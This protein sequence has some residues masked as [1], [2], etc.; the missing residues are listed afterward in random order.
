[1]DRWFGKV[2]IVTGA[3]SGIGETIVEALVKHGIK[4]VGIARSMNRLREL[5]AKFG[6][7]KFYPMECDL[8]KEEDILKAF[9]W[10]EKEL[11]G[12]DI[13]V[14]SAGALIKTPIIDSPTENFHKVID[15]NLIAPAICARETIQSLKKR[16]AAGHIININSMCGH[17]A[18][19]MHIPLGI[20]PASKY[21]VT[22]LTIE[23]RHEIIAANLNVKVTSVSPGI[24]RTNM[25]K[26]NIPIDSATPTLQTTDVAEAII[27]ALQTPE[28]AELIE[29]TLMPHGLA[30]GC[31]LLPEVMKQ[32]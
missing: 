29:I 18:E 9:K 17:F 26:H 23:L 3:S 12:A 8:T 32:L 4:V 2:A 11:G 6:K 21:G 19:S 7:D 27:Y 20:Y 16:N 28:H 30:V 14:N 13:L 24:V 25:L 15:T 5:T 1:M 31:P 10:I 22:A